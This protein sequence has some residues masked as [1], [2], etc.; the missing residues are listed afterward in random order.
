MIGVAALPNGNALDPFWGP[1]V[2]TRS[3]MTLVVSQ[4]AAMVASQHIRWLFQ[5]DVLPREN[6]VRKTENML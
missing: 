6:Q 2:P 5:L 4:N 3:M 1:G